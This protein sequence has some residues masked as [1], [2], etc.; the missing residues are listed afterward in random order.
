MSPAM[1]VGQL[2]NAHSFDWRTNTIGPPS[3]LP[4]HFVL[5]HLL[6]CSKHRRRH[7]SLTWMNGLWSGEATTPSFTLATL[8]LPM[9]ALHR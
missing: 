2:L 1:V 4:H 7:T 8:P 6:H 3:H 9:K 5:S